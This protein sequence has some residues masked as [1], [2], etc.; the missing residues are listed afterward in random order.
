VIAAPVGELL[1]GELHGGAQRRIE[2]PDRN[3]M[4]EVL[5]RSLAWILKPEIVQ[6]VATTHAEERSASSAST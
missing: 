6:L 1:M 2:A 5:N 3:R 4:L